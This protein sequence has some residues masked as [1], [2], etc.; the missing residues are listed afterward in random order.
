M[1]DTKS[2]IVMLF[3]I[4][5]LLIVMTAPAFSAD[6]AFVTPL[7]PQI[8]DNK[9]TAEYVAG[10]ETSR[11]SFLD[12]YNKVHWPNQLTWL[13]V[14][15]NSRL[16]FNGITFGT[17]NTPGPRHLRIGL[18]QPVNVG[19]VITRGKLS[20]LSVLKSSAVYPGDLGDDK[21]WIPAE[22]IR[23]NEVSLWV[24]PPGSATRAFRFTYDSPENEIEHS[25]SLLGMCVLSE[26][27]QNIAPSAVVLTNH[28]NKSATRLNNGK[29][30]QNE[31]WTNED[32]SNNQVIS[33]EHP[34]W[35]M[36]AW[37]KP[38]SLQGICAVYAVFGQTEIQVYTGP[39]DIHP[40]EADDTN[41][42][43]ITSG[44]CAHRSPESFNL[45]WFDFGHTV[46]T[47]AVRLRITSSTDE[48]HYLK[49]QTKDGRICMLGELLAINPVGTEPFKS[50]TIKTDNENTHPPIPITFNLPE[51]GF[52]TLVI[53]DAQG[54]RIKN[55]L[56]DTYFKA[57]NNTVY[58]DGLDESGRID[59]PYAGIY[60]MIG[61]PILPGNYSVRGLYHKQ[62]DLKYEFSVNSPGT[63][64]WLAGSHW[65][66]GTGGWLADH[67]TPSAVLSLPGVQPRLLMTSPV[68]ESSHGI[69][70]T[71]LEGKKLDGKL[72]VGGNWTGASHLTRDNGPQAIADN[73]AY[74]GIVW[75]NGLRL[76]AFKSNGYPIVAPYTFADKQKA[77]LGGLAV[78][79]GLLTATMPKMNAILFVDVPAGKVIGTA[80]LPDGRGLA[81]DDLGRLLAI[82]GQRL[83]RYK[84][85]SREELNAA[86]KEK[87]NEEL[88][89]PEAE[90]LIPQGLLDPQ[91][92][93]IDGKGNIYISDWGT[94]HQVKVFNADGTP[95]RVI[96]APG[97]ARP[98][99]YNPQRMDH[100]LGITVT[101]DNHLWVAEASYS[102]KRVSRWTLDGVLV[103]AFYGPPQYG[104][105]GTI[106]PQNISRFYIG[107]QGHNAGMEFALDWTAGTSKLN[108]IYYLPTADE[109]KLPNNTA[110]QTAIYLNN[111]QYM[112]DVNNSQP[113]GGPRNASIWLMN[114]GLAKPVASFGMARD[115]LVI[116][117]ERFREIW[118]KDMEP[119]KAGW[120]AVNY[121]WSDLNNDSLVSP[122]E[123]SCARNSIGSLTVND[124]L[125]Y[126]TAGAEIFAPEK[127]TDQGVPIY[128]LAKGKKQLENFF[129]NEVSSGSGQIA[130]AHNGWTIGT[131]GMVRGIRD[132][133]IVWTYPNEWPGQQ[134]G[135]FSIPPTHNGELM[136]T[137][138]HMGMIN[139]AG[140]DAGEILV[141][142]G[143]KGNFFLMTTDGI[144][145]A[146]LFH[147][148]RLTSNT[149]TFPEAKRGMILNG[150]TLYDEDFWS[151]VSQ[152]KDG[153]I[154]FVAGKSHSS[155]IKLEGMESTKRLKAG[156]IKVT[157]ALLDEAQQYRIEQETARLARVGRD[158]LS[159]K[160]SQT[161]PVVDGKLDEWVKDEWVTIDERTNARLNAETGGKIESAIR[162][163]GD[164]IYFAYKTNEPNLLANGGDAWQ[165]LF[166]T[167]GALDIMM[168]TNPAASPK[169]TKPEAGDLRILIT[170]MKD[171]TIAVLYQPV[172]PD[173]KEPA[174]FSS[175][176][177][178][179]NF[180]RVSD[181]SA[182]LSFFAKAGNYELSLPLTIL[183][184]TPKDGMEIRGDIGVLRGNGFQTMQ[185]LY[186]QNK[187]TSTVAD[188]PTEATLTPH[189]W[190]I[191]HF[192]NDIEIPTTT[193]KEK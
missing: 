176:W 142:Q 160:I 45:N 151:T 98:G 27:Y 185:R 62:F 9:T 51:A 139:P 17:E 152:T 100:P 82:S 107:E 61:Q 67:S 162:I 15:P 25:G 106:D 92:I 130:A 57:G 104:G 54:K 53:E 119:K 64:P 184:L 101:P 148:V 133:K 181:I 173:V 87:P 135:V 127:F 21:Q 34:E 94:S 124:R 122:D 125:E 33:P 95:L 150:V 154:Y 123:V 161:S 59:G 4:N 116:N 170:K 71:D 115:W 75:E 137:T 29:Y 8:L 189:L 192:K 66:G 6:S 157:Q 2:Q 31:A 35:I 32:I 7:T 163:A 37:E 48:G 110:P 91:G 118:P 20:G 89:L 121:T 47:R 141:I 86:S 145:V 52:V 36:M 158:R 143:D 93:A 49:G 108:N 166:K 182:Q 74:S 43:T 177:R 63:P 172:S 167:G 84:Q 165:L 114:K 5:F 136:A 16:G 22:R 85:L 134:A 55:L 56:G 132:N 174:S 187:A 105:G 19:T 126:C 113:V 41:W 40:K 88:K 178:T 155:I 69:I 164:K 3:L 96:G 140:S 28:N 190:G 97:G 112:T 11:Q 168:S 128:D 10:K 46:T 111:R 78:Y 90:I 68:A 73:Y 72:W 102:P 70:W 58:W 23:N 191:W 179:I 44:V 180:D 169:R 129:M 109:L 183:G 103:K 12:D 26:R 14:M 186:W 79:N 120:D 76:V 81:F 30:D 175:P 50:T 149:W 77:S 188:V 144:F 193:I 159:I 1:F 138:R 80:S 156:E 65:G 60:K 24:L 147:D 18:I 42:K 131:G 146:T 83:L 99:Q 153:K 13:V 171:K 39:D 117:V 38:V